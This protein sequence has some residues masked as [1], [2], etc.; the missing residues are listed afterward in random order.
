MKPFVSHIFHF[1]TKKKY[2]VWYDQNDMQH[3]MLK[4]MSEGISMSSV[5][6]VCASQ[7]YQTSNFC[8]YELRSA[9]ALTPPKPVVVLIVEPNFNSWASPEFAK[10]CNINHNF[11]VDISA[12][13]S[14]VWYEEEGPPPHVYIEFNSVLEKLV[15]L[16]NALKCPVSL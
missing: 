14:D 4:S 15:A 1:L 10:L 11:S 12:F 3:E 13:A 2:R 7:A 6:I 16:L 9:L 5:I 8:M